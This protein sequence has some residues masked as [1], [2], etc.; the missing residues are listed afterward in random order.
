MKV[1]ISYHLADKKHKNKIEEI[2]IENNI[3]YYSV[4][5]DMDVN[6]LS[7]QAISEMIISNMDDCD[8]TFCI[9]GNETYSRPHVD[10]E[11]KAT[12]KGG[13]GI[14]KGLIGIMLETREDN[15]NHIDFN[16]FPG[17]IADNMTDDF[18]YALLIQRASLNYEINSALEEAIIRRDSNISV[19]NSRQLMQLKSRKYYSD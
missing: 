4:P 2:L 14:R 18:D 6:G 1:F 7:H 11:L 13:P 19:N 12:L 16:T 10:H 15:K 5:E 9:I 17:R 3:D 8:V